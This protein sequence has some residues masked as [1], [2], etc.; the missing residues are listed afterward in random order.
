[1]KASWYANNMRVRAATAA[2]GLLV[3]L[4]ATMAAAQRSGGSFGGSRG[5]GSSSSSR[6]SSSNSRPTSWG[7]S[8]RPSYA[9]SRNS[10][11]PSYA[12]SGSS[13]HPSSASS[14]SG[15]SS[16]SSER[17]RYYLADYR[18]P[19][20]VLGVLAPAIGVSVSYRQFSLWLSE[21]EK[22]ELIGAVTTALRTAMTNKPRRG[23]RQHMLSTI[24]FPTDKPK[25]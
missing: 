8:S 1:M 11:H 7:S 21:D 10:Y 19:A 13:Y 25:A 12:P 9:P 23:R 4:Y 22:A 16:R 24:L 3:C 2:I 18:F 20:P 6:S 5:F 14:H 15:A 17:P